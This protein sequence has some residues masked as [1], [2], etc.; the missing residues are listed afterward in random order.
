M[1]HDH[2]VA[3]ENKYSR[4]NKTDASFPGNEFCLQHTGAIEISFDWLIDWF[5]D[6][7]IYSFIYSFIHSFIEC[8][9]DFQ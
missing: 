1:F 8:M 5:I 3:V 6:W 9:I 2:N 7:F 4:R